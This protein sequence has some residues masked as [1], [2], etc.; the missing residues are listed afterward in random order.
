M[1]LSFQERYQAGDSPLHRLDP[2]VKLVTTLL[3]I[4]GIALTPEVKLNCI[5][6]CDTECQYGR[7]C[8]DTITPESVAGAIDMLAQA[9]IVDC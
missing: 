6:C 3:L 7:S 1:G 2:R 4:L 5:P 8:V 9:G